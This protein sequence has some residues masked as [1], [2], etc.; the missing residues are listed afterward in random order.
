[1]I[2]LG[3]RASL[4]ALDELRTYKLVNHT[5]SLYHFFKRVNIDIRKFS[6]SGFLDIFLAELIS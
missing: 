2:K 4:R 5:I 6:Y 1:M 3:S